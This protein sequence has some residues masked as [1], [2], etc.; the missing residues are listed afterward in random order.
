ML[1]IVTPAPDRAAADLLSY[2]PFAR[3]DHHALGAVELEAAWIE[4]QPDELQHFARPA[5]S[6]LNQTLVRHLEQRP[7]GQHLPPVRHEAQILSVV[8]P[9]VLQVVRE[10]R[11]VKEVL[12]VHRQAR[13]ERVTLH[14]N[15]A[16]P[17]KQRVDRARVQEVARQ[18]VD[19]APRR[20]GTRPEPLQVVRRQLLTDH[21][22]LYVLTV[23]APGGTQYPLPEAD[24][25]RPEHLGVRGQDLLGERGARARHP[26][27]EHRTVRSGGTRVG[28][29]QE[30]SAA[31]R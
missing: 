7:G 30:L 16:R 13:V 28:A 5:F 22:T 15:E 2:L 26:D 1:L 17:R 9:Q 11:G 3:R 25:A 23:P 27:D 12:E 18:L 29:R 20:R 10:G 14:M 21:L 24:L 4:L 31:T 19:D 6:I 8:V